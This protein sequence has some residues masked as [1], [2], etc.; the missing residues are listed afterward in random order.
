M[1]VQAAG[2]D[3]KFCPVEPERWLHRA[4]ANSN[5]AKGTM[6]V[7]TYPGGGVPAMKQMFLLPLP[8]LPS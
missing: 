4:A 5:T 3:G 1:E 8:M 7:Y 6:P 2:G